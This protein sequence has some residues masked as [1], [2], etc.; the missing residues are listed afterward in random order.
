MAE[1]NDDLFIVG[2]GA[3]AGGLDALTYFLKHLKKSD[4]PYTIV[5]TQHISPDHQSNLTHLLQN[6]SAWPVREIREAVDLKK[7]YIYVTPPKKHLELQ[8]NS[9]HLVNYDQNKPVPSVDRFFESLAREKGR[10]A[11]GV[12][13]SGTG[14]DGLAGMQQIKSYGGFTLVQQLGNAQHTGM[15]ES[16]IENKAYDKIVLAQ[17]MSHEIEQYIDNFSIISNQKPKKVSEDDEIFELLE[18]RTG[19]DFSKYKPST[20]LRRISKRQD[21][22]NIANKKKYLKYIKDNPKEL[23]TLFETVLIGVTEFFRDNTAFE[24]LKKYLQKIIEQKNGSKDIRIWSVGTATG[25]EAY[26]ICILLAE[27]LQE[28]LNKYNIQIFA[29]D[30]DEKALKIARRGHYAY[31]IIDKLP[32]K[33]KEKYFRRA[34]S[35]YEVAKMLRNMVLF[36]KHDVTTDPPFV[37]LDLIVCRNVMIYFSNELQKEVLPVFHYSLNT[38]GYLFLGKSESVSPREELYEKMESRN[39]IF[40]KAPGN[41][42]HTN[43][44][45]RVRSKKQPKD[46]QAEIKE[47]PQYEKPLV[48]Q[49]KDTFFNDLPYPFVIINSEKEILEVKGSIRLFTELKEGEISVNILKLINPELSLELRAIISKTDKSNQKETS[50]FIKFRVFNNDHFVRLHVYPIEYRKHRRACHMI[51]FETIQPEELL[52]IMGAETSATDEHNEQRVLALEHELSAAKEHLQLFTEE[53]ETSNEELQSLNEELQSTNEELKSSNEELETSNEELQSTNEELQ[54]ANQ[55]LRTSNEELLQKEDEL[56]QSKNKIEESENLYRSLAANFPNGTMNIVAKD[57]TLKFVD[58]TELEN[59]ELNKDAL[60]GRNILSLHEPDQAPK[61]QEALEK[62]F[63]GKTSKT[64]IKYQKNFYSLSVIPLIQKKNTVEEVIFATQNISEQIN[65]QASLQKS[66]DKNTRLLEKEK[67]A[68]KEV[69]H[70]QELLHSIFMNAPA[71]ICILRGEDLVYEFINPICKRLLGNRDLNGMP[72][73]KALPELKGSASEIRMRQVMKTGEPF[74]GEEEEVQYDRQG[75]GNIVKAYFTF[76]YQPLFNNK[77]NIDGIIFFGDDVTDEVA[78]KQKI[79]GE[80]G[81]FKSILESLPMMAWTA[82]PNGEIDYF[83]KRW[84][85]YTGLTWETSKGEGWQQAQHPED[86]EVVHET[87]G[88]VLGQQQAF[89]LEVRY[90]RGSDNIYRWHLNR[91]VPIREGGELKY[92]IGTAFDIHE[93]K[94][95]ELRKDEFLGIASHEL[96]TPLTALRGYYQLIEEAFPENIEMSQIYLKKFDK[97]INRVNKLINELLSVSRIESGNFS[98]DKKENNLNDLLEEVINNF[99][100]DKQRIELTGNINGSFAFDYDRICQV[101]ENLISNAFKY[102][103]KEEKVMMLLEDRNKDVKVTIKDHGI[104]IAKN[105][106]QFLFDR[107]YRV[108]N[109]M[110]AGGLGLGLFISKQI[111]K[112]HGGDIEVQ[113]EEGKGTRFDVI[114]PKNKN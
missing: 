45:S 112:A 114:L 111:V 40:Q 10:K 22:L 70:Q 23:D 95:M 72:M 91:A 90:L 102:S 35:H 29:T 50:R 4:Y 75:D 30:I 73:L 53:L 38:D 15:P 13:L 5:I 62:A 93:Q 48:E 98:L 60:I 63:A 97:S 26:S 57:F 107:Y 37:R 31:A 42:V 101:I 64:I 106:L 27:I 71:A 74:I 82:K 18:N 32:K 81:R 3:S 11:I 44:S 59:L 61:V 84:Y 67:E 43:I 85:E 46:Y 65:L 39:K 54:T 69:T 55:E 25:E 79:K 58:G 28:D 52:A 1:T 34:E 100:K 83:N 16:V 99:D 66:L 17:D 77:G 33:I 68:K 86:L 113:S 9:L 89:E 88:Q 47:S 36:S 110:N 21:E 78:A 19:T 105:E 6:S 104:G 108:K 8:G 14:K 20:L 92:W 76:V 109:K 12:I 94:E 24:D 49:A 7:N 2:I 41:Y 103:P 56:Q 87:L 80:W 51:V 96:K